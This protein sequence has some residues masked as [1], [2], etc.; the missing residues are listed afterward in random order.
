MNADA[1]TSLSLSE[2]RGRIGFSRADVSPPAGIYARLWGSATHDIADGQQRPMLAQCMVLQSSATPDEL[3]LITVDAVALW[4]EEME[5]I[6][7]A[8][9]Q[10]FGLSDAQLMLHPSHTHSSPMLAR[11]HADRPGGELIAPYL[12]SLPATCCELVASARAAAFA[13][14]LS[15]NY[16]SCALA[17]NRDA[18]DAASG[19]GVC[20]LNPARHADDTLLVGRASDESGRTRAVLVN[21]A[22]HPVSLGGA[23]RLLSPDYIGPMR[24]LIEQHSGAPCLFLHGASGDLTPRRSYEAHT[25]AAEQN[26][27]ELGFAALSALN[28]MLP[29]GRQL[30]YQGIEES[31]TALGVWRNAPKGSISGT[32]EAELVPVS[33]PL[34]EF[35][36]RDEIVARLAAATQPFQR[37][38]LERMLAM[39]ERIGEQTVGTL[40]VTVWRVGDALLV[41]TAGEAYSRFQ[42]ALRARF[43][44]SAV[45]VMN[46]TNGA[47]SY[48]PEVGAYQLDVYPVRVTEF[49]PG[50]LEQAIEETTA[51]MQRLVSEPPLARSA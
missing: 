23:N 18:T 44:N 41:A 16:G 24:E 47:N 38:R 11:R 29:P 34:K 27:R 15:W 19:R 50:C 9:K 36:S 31:G 40:P 6:R 42:V 49:A 10:R 37:E 4:K 43:P 21:Y 3:V 33:L 35:P 28:A 8:I 30:S 2:F 32:L 14:I 39:K 12:D 51:I 22:C 7:S 20:G 48:L 1:P 17:F 46:L 5:S 45:A 13:G 26:G 25:E